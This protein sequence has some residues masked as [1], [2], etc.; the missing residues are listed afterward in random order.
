MNW[1]E[2]LYLVV[3][4]I[5][6]AAL[7]VTLP[8]LIPRLSQP[9]PRR[10]RLEAAVLGA[11]VALGLV[12]V[13][14]SFYLGS[15][16]F[17]YSDVGSDTM[18]QYVPY[19]LN[20]IRGVTE[21]TVGP[22]N[23]EYGLG[24]SFMSYQSW[25]LDPFNLVLIPLGIALG[26]SRL[27]LALVI[28]QSLKVVICAYLADHLLTYYCSTPL[29]RI[30]G[31]SL[32]SF[33]G[34]LMLWGQH[35]WIGSIYVMALLMLLLLELLRERWTVPRF[36]GLV[37]GT[38]ASVVMSTYSGFMIM[39]FS[40]IYAALRVAHFTQGK[41]LRGFA[42]SFGRL[43]LP[44]ICGLLVS[45]VTLVP[46]ATLMLGE[47]TRVTGGDGSAL[48]R[49]AEYATSFVPLGWIPMILS[50]LLGN[51][52]VSS[53]EA[54]PADV[55][56]PTEQFP[57]VNVYEVVVIGVTGAS[58][59][60][61]ALFA[62]WA[63]RRAS[64]RD[65]ALIGVAAALVVLYCVNFFLPT[66]FNALVNPKYR[67]SFAVAIPLCLAMAV[68]WERVVMRREAS[69]RVVLP[70]YA[71]TVV[72]LVWSLLNTVN[73][74]ALCLFYLVA[75]TALCAT[76]LVAGTAAPDGASP[77]R[78][79]LLPLMTALSCALVVS[80][81]IAD[82]FIT[83]NARGVCTEED[84]PLASEDGAASDTAQALAYLRESDPTLWR[85][86]KT[87]DD[88]T[89]LD[90]SL[91]Q[92]YRGVSSYNSTLDSD[93]EEFYEK[94]WPNALV[95]DVAY[96][97]FMSDPL[98]PELHD[99]LGVKYVLSRE[100]LDWAGL[101]L[102]TKVGDVLVYRNQSVSG[103]ATVREGVVTESVA[104]A[105]G[106]DE[107]RRQ[108]LSGCAIVPDE[109]G[110][111]L[112]TAEWGQ[113]DLVEEFER[114]AG[115]A[116]LEELA[117]TLPYGMTISEALELNPGYV[118]SSMAYL[119]Q[120]GGS[121]MSG[122]VF[123]DAPAVVCLSVP[124]TAG[125]KVLVDGEEVETF[126]TNYGFVGFAVSAGTHSI[127]ASFEPQGVAVGLGLAAA[128]LLLAAASCAVIRLRPRAE[129]GPAASPA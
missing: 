59:I 51:S 67:S 124:N 92:G 80:M 110:S 57:Y 32:L 36:A 125:W 31:A 52:L 41:G 68:A 65:R 111:V 128:G 72:V 94:L 74:R 79:R 22:W 123:T 100:E 126:R 6:A 109:K 106:S 16:Y 39:L 15:S 82:G 14:G 102:E 10:D 61:L 44:V 46:Y 71:L 50:R 83:T 29:A 24:T 56:A 35:Y 9:T 54:I 28:V 75:T 60:L 108:L 13:Y 18:E 23:F 38:A 11:V 85:V 33:G 113:V 43:A 37:A 101:T 62:W 2:H 26:T 90:D 98:H 49:A 64:R 21:G 91:V 96:Q 20:L 119:E 42:A 25:T 77:A 104:D 55:M 117:V 1:S 69:P 34:Y 7:L 95:G 87:Y 88:W 73:G 53:G 76:L 93:I 3:P 127:E 103:I 99:I 84:F 8:R 17:A 86:E 122:A 115:M 63:L 58:L 81:A 105:L 19:Y 70:A 120:T 66:L 107:A 40:A 30:L 97:A 89:S 47:S 114:F 12:A 5:G 116:P 4:L 78:E 27:A 121:S 118:P 112:S 129:S 48:S 45:A